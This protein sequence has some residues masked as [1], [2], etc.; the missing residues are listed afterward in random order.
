MLSIELLQN[1]HNKPLSKAQCTWYHPLKSS[2]LLGKFCQLNIQTQYRKQV[3][4]TTHQPSPELCNERLFCQRKG[5]LTCSELN[6]LI[7]K[8]QC[9]KQQVSKRAGKIS[10]T[11]HKCFHG[12][13]FSSYVRARWPAHFA[14][15]GLNY[16]FAHCSN[17]SEMWSI[18][19]DTALTIAFV[20]V[21]AL[22]FICLQGV[23]FT[24]AKRLLLENRED[25]FSFFGCFLN[26]TGCLP[27]RIRVVHRI[28]LALHTQSLFPYFQRE[29]CSVQEQ[30]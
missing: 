7:I 26:P 16:G 2:M 10:V 9:C 29:N 14:N 11:H 5:P 20:S 13:Y 12:H 1:I 24:K 18:T 6:I 25:G 27:G 22:F 4:F 15:I 3:R 19:T 23:L 21:L 8:S 30:W 28:E 17:S